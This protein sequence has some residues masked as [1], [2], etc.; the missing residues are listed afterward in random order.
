MRVAFFSMLL[1]MPVAASAQDLMPMD[2]SGVDPEL[3]KSFYGPWVIVD[4]SGD[5]TCKVELKDEP[6]IGGSV[7][8]IDPHCPKVF[9]IMEEIGAWR[10][11]ESW[12]IDLVDATR[13]T[14]IR[15]TTPDAAYVADPEVDGIFTILQPQQ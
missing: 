9:P 15:F 6:T 1:A 4:R 11:M 13:K 5:K 3:L 12:G 14:R 7:I 8:D 10:L 2:T